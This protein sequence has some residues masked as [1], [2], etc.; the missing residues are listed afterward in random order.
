MD[1]YNRGTRVVTIAA[2]AKFLSVPERDLEMLREY[3][4]EQNERKRNG[5]SGRMI[6]R[7]LRR[8]VILDSQQLPADPVVNPRSIS[9]RRNLSSETRN[10]VLDR[11]GRKCRYC[12][13]VA[14]NHLQVDHIFPVSRGGTDDEIN[15]VAA[16]SVCNRRKR[17]NTV[18]ESGMRLRR[19]RRLKPDENAR[20]QKLAN[21][22]WQVLYD[23]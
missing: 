13:N 23:E 5:V 17:G 18:A 3:A 4:I 21:G 7:L 10:R 9:G 15:L 12:G 19:I 22:V 6:V 8:A 11:D 16:C 2:L 20:Q 14:R 1:D